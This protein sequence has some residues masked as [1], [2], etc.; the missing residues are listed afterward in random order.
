MSLVNLNLNTIK[1]VYCE[2]RRSCFHASNQIFPTKLHTERF[3]NNNCFYSWLT[4]V[5]SL[6]TLWSEQF[7]EDDDEL[8][9][10]SNVYSW[11][12]I[13]QNGVREFLGSFTSL[14]LLEIW[15]ARWIFYNFFLVASA[16]H[17]AIF[18]P[19]RFLK[20]RKIATPSSRLERQVLNLIPSQRHLQHDSWV[21]I[22][23][24][25]SLTK[26]SATAKNC[27]L[28]K[29]PTQQITWM[30]EGRK[31]TF[32]RNLMICLMCFYAPDVWRKMWDEEKPDMMNCWRNLWQHTVFIFIP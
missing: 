5:A 17:N 8:I 2:L 15:K 26:K 24:K 14:L 32:I 4:F 28:T 7:A 3:N 31:L 25:Y 13:T 27:F 20:C 12:C 21:F 11:N 29:K 22:P 9:A 1:L 18:A 6:L 19:G 30:F 23:T 16:L 10:S